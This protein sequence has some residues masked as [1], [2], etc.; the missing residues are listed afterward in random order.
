MD[1]RQDEPDG[2]LSLQVRP[3]AGHGLLLQLGLSNQPVI[4]AFRMAILDNDTP[5]LAIAP[6][7]GRTVWPEG[8]AIGF[9]I[10][11]NPAPYYPL[12]LELAVTETGGYIDRRGFAANRL[13]TIITLAAAQSSVGLHRAHR[14]RPAGP[15]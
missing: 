7:G 12:V 2:G 13:P 9:T 3:P 14:R 15:A 1:D 10:T 6:V 11:A 4:G 5:G 8:A